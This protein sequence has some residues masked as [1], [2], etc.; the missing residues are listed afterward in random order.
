LFLIEKANYFN[1]ERNN[2][3]HPQFLISSRENLAA[4]EEVEERYQTAKAKRVDLEREMLRKEKDL[5]Q[6]FM[7]IQNLTQ[8]FPGTLHIFG[9]P[10]E[11]PCSAA[12][13]DTEASS[14]ESDSSK[15]VHVKYDDGEATV[16]GPNFNVR[17]QVRTHY[18][19]QPKRNV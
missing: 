10:V 7:D 11:R 15:W 1:W 16:L 6:V 12:A 13:N 5:C 2:R 17:T 19:M 14:D 4:Y 9:L 3:D 8:A 18:A